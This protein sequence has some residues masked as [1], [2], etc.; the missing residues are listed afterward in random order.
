MRKV[1]RKFGRKLQSPIDFP[2][3]RGRRDR[4]HGGQRGRDGGDAPGCGQRGRDEGD[5]LELGTLPSPGALL[6]GINYPLPK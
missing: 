3:D 1:R 6:R 5:L 2:P 4:R